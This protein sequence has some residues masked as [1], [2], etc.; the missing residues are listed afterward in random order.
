MNK[1]IASG[2]LAAAMACCLPFINVHEGESLESYEDVVGVWTICHG[3]THGITPGMTKTE[4][5]CDELTKSTLAQFMD[6]VAAALT[7]QPSPKLLAAHTS[8]AY[9]IGISGYR[10]SSAL[11]ETNKGNFEAGCHAMSSWHSAGG[12]NCLVKANNCYGLIKRRSDEI[13][14]C[15][16]GIQGSSR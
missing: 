16:A 15:L 2:I 12:K 1:K 8:F 3:I 6:E 7:I 13:A 5:E 9:N 10:G 14:L 4:A 11:R